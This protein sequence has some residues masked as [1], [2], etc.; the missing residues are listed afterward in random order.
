MFGLSNTESG[1]Y[2]FVSDYI[3]DVVTNA[4]SIESGVKVDAKTIENYYGEICFRH[5]I[6]QYLDEWVEFLPYAKQLPFIAGQKYFGG[7]SNEAEEALSDIISAIN[8]VLFGNTISEFREDLEKLPELQG[9]ENPSF[10]TVVNVVDILLKKSQFSTI[11][12]LEGLLTVN[13]GSYPILSNFKLKL[14]EVD[15]TTDV[16]F[17]DKSPTSNRLE[18]LKKSLDT[19]PQIYTELTM[20]EINLAKVQ[21]QIKESITRLQAVY[22][23]NFKRDLKSITTATIKEVPDLYIIMLQPNLLLKKDQK[24]LARMNT[25]FENLD[26]GDDIQSYIQQ[27]FEESK[28]TD[29]KGM[30][31]EDAIEKWV[32]VLDILIELRK[33]TA[34]YQEMIDS[35]EPILNITEIGMSKHFHSMFYDDMRVHILELNMLLNEYWGDLK[36]RKNNTI[37]RLSMF[38]QNGGMFNF[39]LVWLY[40]IDYY[41]YCILEKIT[42]LWTDFGKKVIKSAD[43][44]G[45]WMSSSERMAFF[46]SLPKK[47]AGMDEDK[48]DKKDTIETFVGAIMK[49]G[50][51]F[52]S[53]AD[54]FLS[55]VTVIT[56]PIA[57]LKFLIGWIVAIILMIIW[58]ILALPPFLLLYGFIITVYLSVI[59]SVLWFFVFILFSSLYLVLSILDIFFGGA[60]MRMLRCENLPNLWH[61]RNNWHK[62]NKYDRSLFCS[63]PCR[64][65]F[66]PFGGIFCMRQIKHEPTYAPHQLIYSAFKKN[67]YL[68]GLQNNMVYNHKVNKTLYTEM[69]EKMKVDNWRAAY[70]SEQEY[71]VDIRDK[72]KKYEK[73]VEG[74]CSQHFQKEKNEQ[75]G[76]M[77]SVCKSIFCNSEVTNATMCSTKGKHGSLNVPDPLIL[78]FL[79]L[80]IF[81]LVMHII[82]KQYWDGSSE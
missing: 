42:P 62:G 70:A 35:I 47:F 10:S 6:L 73:L 33:H 26:A 7:D 72:Y 24:G 71:I 30:V 45:T 55:I 28:N 38:R 56:D 17:E 41:E 60:I 54:V 63:Q 50:A 81:T 23:E 31:L 78:V 9:I 27:Y 2:E 44:I 16:F 18:K 34:T 65:S 11:Q 32:T 1:F 80:C 4:N 14:W 67:A 15:E 39:T 21:T 25:F 79:K 75:N 43:D 13:T 22:K 76:E 49:I 40:M 57:F 68:H 51:A 46:M 64:K 19:A 48:H 66:Y 52:V 37:V 12:K 3:K 29:V 82:L 74:I 77:I 69:N 61:Q 8:N 20:F 59:G 53:I 58:I 5:P 36:G